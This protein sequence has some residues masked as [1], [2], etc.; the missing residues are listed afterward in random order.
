MKQNTKKMPW[1]DIFD[2]EFYHVNKVL[3]IVYVV[4]INQTEATPP[5]PE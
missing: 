2:F 5:E 4:K 3:K 1:D